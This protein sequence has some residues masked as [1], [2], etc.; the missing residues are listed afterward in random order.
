MKQAEKLPLPDRFIH[1]VIFALFIFI[2]AVSHRFDWDYFYTA[3]EAD[4]QSWILHHAPPFWS[5]SFCA[6]SPR[7]ADPQAFGLSPLF[8]FALLFGPVLGAKLLYL[9]LTVLGYFSLKYLLSNLTG[10][11][12]TLVSYLSLYFVLGFYFFWHAHIGNVTFALIH[13]WL[14]GLALSVC[15]VQ[16]PSLRAGTMLALAVLIAAGFTA[17]FYH[18]VVFFLL[19]AG[20]V[21]YPSLFFLKRIHVHSAGILQ[22]ASAT[23]LGLLLSSYKW[24]PVIQHQLESP[25]SLTVKA[26]TTV[27]ENYSI[28]DTAIRLLLPTYHDKY[29]GG[30]VHAE[31]YG[32]WEYSTFSWNHITLFFCL[33]LML[34]SRTVTNINVLVVAALL[35]FVGV[36]LALADFAPWS[37]FALLNEY[38]FHDAL[39]AAGRFLIVASLGITL[40]QAAALAGLDATATRQFLNLQRAGALV[41][42]VVPLSFYPGYRGPDWLSGF[43]YPHQLPQKLQAVIWLPTDEAGNPASMYPATARGISVLDCYSPLFQERRIQGGGPAILQQIP[44]NQAFHFV[45]IPPDTGTDIRKQCLEQSF[46]TSRTIHL[47]QACPAGSCIFLNSIAPDD[48]V[49]S[50]LELYEGLYCKVQTPSKERPQE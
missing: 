47:D 37:P 36:M 48:P 17:G 4:L 46:Y 31:F 18:S 7:I 8:V 23:G 15:L 38:I 41:F 24:L 1:A 44:F 5:Y 50:S 9:G 11:K 10:A 26:S 39:R 27:E 35:I 6:G 20:I 29:W 49:R 40:F 43:H 14:G 22:A 28:L 3:F 30:F 25:R 16:S 32:I 45:K 2:L 13:L 34:R 12:N 42:L 19:P 33:F 21:F